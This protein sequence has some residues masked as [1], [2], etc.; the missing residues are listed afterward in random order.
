VLDG[1]CA[2]ER[3]ALADVLGHEEKI[4]A[5]QWTSLMERYTATITMDKICHEKTDSQKASKT[6]SG[7]GEEEDKSPSFSRS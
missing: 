1:N 2:E 6:L 5:K 3:Y 4:T 7:I